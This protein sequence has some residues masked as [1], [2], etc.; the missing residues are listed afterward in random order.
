[1]NEL[2]VHPKV[3]YFKVLDTRWQHKAINQETTD[4]EKKKKKTGESQEHTT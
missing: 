2:M 1:M 4:T 3:Q